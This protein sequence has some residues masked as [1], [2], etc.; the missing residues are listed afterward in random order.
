MAGGLSRRLKT[1]AVVNTHTSND[2]D[3]IGGFT[4]TEG[5]FIAS[6]KCRIS[7]KSNK[8]RFLGDRS[9]VEEKYKI[10]ALTGQ[11]LKAG[12]IV[13]DGSARYELLGVNRPSKGIHEEWDAKRLEDKV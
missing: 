4:Q 8:E 9:D 3:G 2:D 13:V 7:L 11:A 10:F 1:T 12:M 5:V 6:F